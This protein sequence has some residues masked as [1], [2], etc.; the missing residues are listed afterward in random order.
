MILIVWF[1]VALSIVYRLAVWSVGVVVICLG[2]VGATV[3][4]LS[5]FVGLFLISVDDDVC[6]LVRKVKLKS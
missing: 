4:A 1:V 3:V 5:M 2:L 6:E